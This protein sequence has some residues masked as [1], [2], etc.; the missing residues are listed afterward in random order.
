MPRIWIDYCQFMVQQMQLTRTRQLFNRALCAL[1][2]TQHYRIWPLFLSFVQSHNI[3]EVAVRIFKRYLKVFPY[4]YVCLQL[5]KTSISIF[6][7][8]IFL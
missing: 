3:P 2:V 8:L 6:N 7:F 5:L 1:P 4:L